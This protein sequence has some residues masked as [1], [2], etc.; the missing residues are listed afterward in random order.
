VAGDRVLGFRF[1]DTPEADDA[2]SSKHGMVV[3]VNTPG[4]ARL[5]LRYDDVNMRLS[6]TL[7]GATF[8]DEALDGD[9]RR[10]LCDAIAE[11][12]L[13]LA[14]GPLAGHPERLPLRLVGD[15]ARRAHGPSR[16]LRDAA[17]ARQPTRPG[18]RPQRRRRLRGALPQPSPSRAWRH[19]RA[20]VDGRPLRIGD[21]PFAPTRRWCLATH[22]NPVTGV[23]DR[24]VRRRDPRFLARE[25]NV[26]R[27]LVPETAGVIRLGDQ[28]TVD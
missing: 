8:A 12:V 16:W 20:G 19:G 9:G 11:Y 13:Q 26:C 7:D 24:Q 4:L 1:A 21:V 25:A 18:L 6:I 27:C 17:R 28:L 14:E 10:R 15:G 2:W 23:R 3:L 5:R 22:A